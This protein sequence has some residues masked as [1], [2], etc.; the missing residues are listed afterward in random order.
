M[1]CLCKKTINCCDIFTSLKDLLKL[2]ILS[3]GERICQSS[4][5]ESKHDAIF[6][7][8]HTVFYSPYPIIS[9]TVLS[10]PRS[11]APGASYDRSSIQSSF[12]PP[13]PKSGLCPQLFSSGSETSNGHRQVIGRISLWPL[14][15]TWT[16][17]TCPSYPGNT[18]FTHP[19]CHWPRGAFWSTTSTTSPTCKLSLTSLHFFRLLSVTR[20]FSLHRF[21]NIFTRFWINLHWFLG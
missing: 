8:A 2:D 21:Q 1:R 5:A 13:P 10:P 11:G 6:P 15:I 19:R 14:V 18:S 17:H 20:N 4:N 9:F 12:H 3:G 16:T 7:C